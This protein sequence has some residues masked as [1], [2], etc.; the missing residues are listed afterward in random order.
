MDYKRIALTAVVAWVVDSAYGILVWMTM[1]E[2]EFA[3]YPTVFRPQ[4]AMNAYMPLMFAGSLLAMFV[5]SYIYAKG[6]EGGPGLR[7]GL[8]F[9]VVVGLFL[10][11]F[12]SLGLYGSLNIGRRMG[13]LASAAVFAEMIVVG[14]VI[15]VMYRPGVRTRTAQAAA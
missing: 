10:F 9:G 2:R 14:I 13:V 4:A 7:E 1:L 8:R 5:L 3:Q 15:G 11:G 6:Y 12:V